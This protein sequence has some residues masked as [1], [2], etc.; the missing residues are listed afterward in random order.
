M[1]MSGVGKSISEVQL[2]DL[3]EGEH[4]HSKGLNDPH[5]CNAMKLRW[6]YLVYRRLTPPSQ[7]DHAPCDF[8]LI[9]AFMWPQTLMDNPDAF[10]EQEIKSWP[11]QA[12]ESMAKWVRQQEGDKYPQEKKQMMTNR[13]RIGE[14]CSTLLEKVDSKL[15]KQLLP[16]SRPKTLAN[17]LCTTSVT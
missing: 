5:F 14:Y 17:L 8:R 9:L 3:L 7:S 2:L 11:K 4:P 12:N 15:T 6:H 10:T 13:R 1:V 16:A